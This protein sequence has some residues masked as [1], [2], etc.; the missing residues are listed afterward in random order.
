MQLSIIIIKVVTFI[1]IFFLKQS[2]DLPTAKYCNDLKNSADEYFIILSISCS[3]LV[4][5]RS[6][7]DSYSVSNEFKR[8]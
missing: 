7:R 1:E 2:M 6:H 5:N 4:I 8:I 3:N